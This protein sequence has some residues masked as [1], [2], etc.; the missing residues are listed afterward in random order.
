M[1]IDA[2]KGC[3]D[4]KIRPV[5]EAITNDESMQILLRHIKDGWP[6]HKDQVPIEIRMCYD[7]RDTQFSSYQ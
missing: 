6:K 3:D 4:E 1:S 5:R 7:L 2:L